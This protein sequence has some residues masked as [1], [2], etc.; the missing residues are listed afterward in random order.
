[1]MGKCLPGDNIFQLML[2]CLIDFGVS[3]GRQDTFTDAVVSAWRINILTFFGVS[4]WKQAILTDSGE[5]C[6]RLQI[7]VYNMLITN[8]YKARHSSNSQSRAREDYIKYSV[9]K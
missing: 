8:L 2:E 5:S 4:S 9:Y 6:S 3:Y 7:S 1:M